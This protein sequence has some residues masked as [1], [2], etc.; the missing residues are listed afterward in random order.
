MN[1]NN[2]T[3]ND[4][5]SLQKEIFKNIF[6]HNITP[7]QV[8]VTV[9]KSSLKKSNKGV[10]TT[11]L[12]SKTKKFQ[13]KASKELKFSPIYNA[14][15]QNL[16]RIIDEIKG[17]LI[18]KSRKI[19]ETKQLFKTPVKRLEKKSAPAKRPR[20]RPR[21]IQPEENENEKN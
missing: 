19:N 1:S 21:K 12:T 8:N 16:E 20:G 3:F 15:K 5:A 6:Q 10:T 17:K 18:P 13:V 9:P 7:D 14:K 11:P 4:F 2:V